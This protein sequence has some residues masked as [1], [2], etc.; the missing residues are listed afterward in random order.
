[1]NGG[2]SSGY[3][4]LGRGVRQGDPLSAYLLTIVIE[5]LIVAITADPKI[6]SIDVAGNSIC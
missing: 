5:L 6:K 4:S 2:I 3:F 1:M